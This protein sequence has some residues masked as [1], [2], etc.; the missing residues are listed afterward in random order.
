[1][2]EIEKALL[3]KLCQKSN[4]LEDELSAHFDAVEGSYGYNDNGMAL[5]TSLK[6]L[7]NNHLD[8]NF[9]LLNFGMIEKVSNEVKNA[10][11]LMAA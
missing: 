2:F 3:K 5:V 11:K 7:H 10:V 1:M 4:S 8:N 6:L 9:N